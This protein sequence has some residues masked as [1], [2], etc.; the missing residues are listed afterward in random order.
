METAEQ[1]GVEGTWGGGEV[2]LLH[3]EGPSS[4]AGQ[5]LGESW[6]C[7]RE[8]CLAGQLLQCLP[9]PVWR[10]FSKIRQKTQ[11]ADPFIEA[12]NDSGWKRPLRS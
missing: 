8:D 12:W 5:G 4:L 7:P 6:E 10:P 1:A 11:A 3:H 2:S 9:A